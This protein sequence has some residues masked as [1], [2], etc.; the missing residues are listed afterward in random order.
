MIQEFGLGQCPYVGVQS[1]LVVGIHIDWRPSLTGN[2][3]E[4][5]MN[6]KIHYLCLSSYLSIYIWVYA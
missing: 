3:S 4:Q 2:M 1:G 6:F 5:V